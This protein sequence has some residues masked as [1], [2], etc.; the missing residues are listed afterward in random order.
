MSVKYK[1][2]GWN[3]QKRIYDATLAALVAASIAVFV[4]GAA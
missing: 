1:P 2:V 3:R 4:P